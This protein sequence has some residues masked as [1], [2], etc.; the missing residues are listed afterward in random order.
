[1]LETAVQP[2]ETAPVANELLVAEEKLSNVCEK[3]PVKLGDAARVGKA[4][5]LL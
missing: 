1:V 4:T 2:G 3:D 5:T